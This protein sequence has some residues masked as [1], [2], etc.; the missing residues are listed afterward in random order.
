MGRLSPV[1]ID[2][3]NPSKTNAFKDFIVNSI[4]N[5]IEQENYLAAIEYKKIAQNT[6]PDEFGKT[7]DD[8]DNDVILL[9]VCQQKRLRYPS[10]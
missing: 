2:I 10:K 7:S 9:L 5:S 6:W 8:F 1:N 4:L 3:Q